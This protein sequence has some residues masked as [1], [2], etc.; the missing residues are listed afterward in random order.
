M[1]RGAFVRM[2]VCL[3]EVTCVRGG[4]VRWSLEVGVAGSRRCLRLLLAA[5]SLDRCRALP[6]PSGPARS[7]PHSPLS[8]SVH[9]VGRRRQIAILGPSCGVLCGVLSWGHLGCLAS[10]ILGVLSWGHDDDDD[11]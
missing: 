1:P 6:G 9:A 5:F 3:R 7:H 2:Y 10:A 8:V 4:G 11:G